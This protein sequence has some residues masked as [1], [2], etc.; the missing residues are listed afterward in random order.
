M[1][2]SEKAEKSEEAEKAEKAEK[3]VKSGLWRQ[4]GEWRG[5]TRFD[6]PSLNFIK[7]CYLFHKNKLVAR[8]QQKFTI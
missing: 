6:T 2:K 4:L 5:N 1:V 7:H 8:C 3:L